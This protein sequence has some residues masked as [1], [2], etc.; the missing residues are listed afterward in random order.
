MDVFLPFLLFV[1]VQILM[2]IHYLLFFKKSSITWLH[3]DFY[4]LKLLNFTYPTPF[5]SFSV[6]IWFL[7][8]PC[9][10]LNLLCRPSLAGLWE[11]SASLS[12]VG[13]NGVHQMCYLQFLFK[14]CVCFSS[15]FT[16]NKIITENIKFLFI[17]S[18]CHRVVHHFEDLWYFQQ[19]R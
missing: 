5:F 8:H 10:F 11:M 15:V 16:T 17:I 9:L 13:I 3:P 4:L 1:A 19:H 2:L 12:S 18:S 14:V 7:C 6:K